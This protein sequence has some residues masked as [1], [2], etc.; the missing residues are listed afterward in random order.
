MPATDDMIKGVRIMKATNDDAVEMAK[1]EL[2]CFGMDPDSL[3][4]MYQIS[5]KITAS[6]NTVF[7]AVAPGGRIIGGTVSYPTSEKFWLMDSLFVHPDYRHHGIGRRLRTEGIKA[8]WLRP[9]KTLVNVDKPHLVGFYEG[10]GFRV[11]GR[12]DDFFGNGESH[13]VMVKD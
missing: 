4:E 9:V 13:H 7:K 11:N 6:F 3:D 10:F 2:E 1:L 8:A 12:V 5:W